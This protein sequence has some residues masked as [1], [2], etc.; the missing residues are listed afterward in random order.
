MVCRG[1]RGVLGAGRD[2]QY[3]GTRRGIGGIGDIGASRGVWSFGGMGAS[4]GVEG[5]RLYWG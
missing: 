5:V 1:V 2:S 3:S 4:G